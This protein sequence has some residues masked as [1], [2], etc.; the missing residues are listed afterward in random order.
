MAYGCCASTLTIRTWIELFIIF[1]LR[2][3]WYN[4]IF[5][6]FFFQF[7]KLVILQLVQEPLFR[8]Y[9]ISCN[10]ECVHC[11]FFFNFARHVQCSSRLFLHPKKT[12]FLTA[13]HDWTPLN[14]LRLCQYINR[15]QR[16]TWADKQKHK[17]NFHYIVSQDSTTNK[18]LQV[19][20]LII[21]FPS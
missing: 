8:V 18:Y 10:S 21:A 12:V 2:K 4:S 15:T 7:L 19:D 3:A 14:T 1:L 13:A 16:F 17:L 20:M 6:F 5:F 11:R 9:F